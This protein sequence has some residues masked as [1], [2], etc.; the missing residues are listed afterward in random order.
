MCTQKTADLLP[1]AGKPHWVT[2]RIDLV[3]SMGKGKM[4][5]NP[6]NSGGSSSAESPGK[7]SAESLDHDTVKTEDNDTLNDGNT[8]RHVK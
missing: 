2:R 7:R 1:A 4:V 6:I 3:N 8:E 5:C